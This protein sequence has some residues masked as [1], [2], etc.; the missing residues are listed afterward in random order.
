MTIFMAHLFVDTWGWPTL[1]DKHEGRY[2][3]IAQIFESG[4][5]PNLVNGQ[6]YVLQSKA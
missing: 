6:T 4:L 3:D 5:F 2:E 1:R